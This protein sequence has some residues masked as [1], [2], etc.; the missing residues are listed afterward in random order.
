MDLPLLLAGPILR[1]VEPTLVSVWVALRQPATIVPQ[2]WEGQAQSGHADIFLTATPDT[3]R[4]GANRY[5]A[6]VTAA[7][8]PVIVRRGYYAA[9]RHDGRLHVW[10]GN[11][12]S[13]GRGEAS[14]GLAFDALER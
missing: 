3:I 1:R 13:V 12:A 4:L 5:L 11:Q 7:I 2:V 6:E 10:A 14:S 8:G 9:R